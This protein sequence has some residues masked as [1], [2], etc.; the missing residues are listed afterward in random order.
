MTKTNTVSKNE[1]RK[2]ERD[3]KGEGKVRTNSPSDTSPENLADVNRILGQRHV[4]NTEATRSR[5][6]HNH[7]LLPEELAHPRPH[8]CMADRLLTKRILSGEPRAEPGD[9]Q[10]GGGGGEAGKTG[11]E[12]GDKLLHADGVVLGVLDESVV[13]VELDGA[14]FGDAVG[15]VA[16]VEVGLEA[17]DG[18]DEFCGFD[19]LL[20]LRAGNRSDVDLQTRSRKV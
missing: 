17:A 8:P 18:D 3:G 2:D 7:V 5:L 10:L 9:G 16:G 11:D 4:Q 1:V 19:L 12:F 15:E 6:T 20:D 13:G 14:L